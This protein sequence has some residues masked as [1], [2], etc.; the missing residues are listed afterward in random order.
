M[1][2]R[3]WSDLDRRLDDAIDA[4]NDAHAPDFGRD[5]DE[6]SLLDTLRVVRRLRVPVEP[7][8]AF[9][10]R[11]VAQTLAEASTASLVSYPNGAGETHQTDVTVPARLTTRRYR[12]IM[13]QIA[14]ILRVVGVFVLAGMLSG[15]LVGGLGGRVVMRVS[16]YLYQRENPG[17]TILTENSGEPVGQISLQGTID[18][19]VELAVSGAAIGMLLLLVAPWLSHSGWRRA[20]GFGL[21]VLSLVGPMV[22]SPGSRDLRLFG[23]VPL[24]IAM[25]ATLIVAAGMLTTPIFGWLDRS[26]VARHRL[27]PRIGAAALRPVVVVLGGIGLLAV[28]LLM[29]TNVIFITFDALTNPRIETIV[30]L[31][32]VLAFAITLPLARI[33][34]AFPNHLTALDRLR[35][36]S[37]TRFLTVALWLLTVAGLLLL[38]TNTIRIAAG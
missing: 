23:P 24:N 8:T 38:L 12:L 30:L 1:S 32:L 9:E 18:L 21:I 17:V 27:L 20:G 13:G 5:D 31:P 10:D 29:V 14:A 4:L 16:G 11:L 35:S 2:E 15:A 28:V 22:I 6:L 33:A 7:D 25:F 36:A 26:L 19:I 34:V 3:D 37:A